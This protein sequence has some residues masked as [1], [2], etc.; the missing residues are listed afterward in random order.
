MPTRRRRTPAASSG[1]W[2]GCGR[3]GRTR[4]QVPWVAAAVPANA[5]SADEARAAAAATGIG[6]MRGGHTSL[7]DEGIAAFRWRVAAQPS[8]GLREG[9][10]DPM[11]RWDFKLV[12]VRCQWEIY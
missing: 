12:S 6:Q 7:R 8:T 1:H 10:I 5:P 9:L 11:S 4:H 3:A 2:H